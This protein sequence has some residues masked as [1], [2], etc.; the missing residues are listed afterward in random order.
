MKRLF[1]SLLSLLILLM[2]VVPLL[3]DTI[4][5]KDGNVIQGQV[6]GFKDGQ[7]TVLIGNGSKGKRSRTIV[8]VE[9]V[10]T[11]DFSSGPVSSIV[12]TDNDNTPSEPVS[13][14]SPQSSRPSATPDP[15]F[16]APTG[17]S[18]PTAAPPIPVRVPSENINNGWASTGLSVRRGQRILITASGRVSLG[19]DASGVAVFSTPA[20][21]PNVRDTG[22]LMDKEPTGGLIAVIGDDNDDFI[23]IGSRYEFVAQ[24]DGLLYLGVNEGTLS[25]NSGSYDVVIKPFPLDFQRR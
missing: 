22:K 14:P 10:E 3:G 4:K 6:V 25:N 24:H 5:L 7:F 1:H 19:K 18:Q 23:F 8:Y 9:D 11:I 16:S 20:G 17:S 15:P 12:P 21:L 13:Q 2:L